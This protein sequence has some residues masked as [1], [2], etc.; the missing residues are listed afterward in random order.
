SR[1]CRR[2][3]G[4][5]SRLAREHERALD[6]LDCLGHL[7]AT[8]AGLRAVECGPAAP[9][10]VDL[11]EDVQPLGGTLVAAVE[12]EPVRVDDG[13][14]PEVAAL[15]PEHRATGGVRA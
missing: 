15:V 10:T 3:I 4:R 11:V 14:R 5:R 1:G 7:D 6:L 13:R 2:K 12:D 8:R 9:D